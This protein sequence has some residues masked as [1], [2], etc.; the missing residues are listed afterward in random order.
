MRDGLQLFVRRR[1]SNG[2]GKLQR[3]RQHVSGT[4]TNTDNISS[5]THTHTDHAQSEIRFKKK[6]RKKESLPA[7]T[8]EGNQS[9]KVWEADGRHLQAESCGEGITK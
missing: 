2:L 7:N 8:V 5:H 6:E 4:Q 1:L 9:G 3:E